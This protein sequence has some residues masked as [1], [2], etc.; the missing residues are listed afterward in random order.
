MAYRDFEVFA[1][2]LSEKVV[3]LPVAWNGRSLSSGTID[4][5][6]VVRTF[7]QELN[8]MTLGVAD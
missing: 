5:D 2:F 8:T 4:I 6:A 7:S 1:D 3:D